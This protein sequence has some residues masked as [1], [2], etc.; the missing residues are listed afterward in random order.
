[1]TGSHR[2]LQVWFERW[3]VRVLLPL[4]TADHT[5]VA[6]LY[7]D[8]VDALLAA[9]DPVTWTGWR[10]RAWILLTTQTGLRASEL[11]GLTHGDV[12]LW[13]G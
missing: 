7:H 5:I 13:V 6:F 8:K 12:R 4:T 3:M 1:M 10:D 9:T 2:P 11:T